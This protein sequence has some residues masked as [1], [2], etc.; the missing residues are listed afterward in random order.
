MSERAGVP[1]PKPKWGFEPNF[2]VYQ[3]GVIPLYYE[4][5][6]IKSDIRDLNPLP[7]AWQADALPNEL[8]SL[9]LSPIEE[10][11]FSFCV[12]KAKLYH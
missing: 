6:I 9:V 10:S 2:P 11:N 5:V 4:G 8:I 3:T 12:T 1:C 7:S